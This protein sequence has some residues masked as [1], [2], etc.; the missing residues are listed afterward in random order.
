MSE[1]SP[2]AAGALAHVI[3]LCAAP[4]FKKSESEVIAAGLLGSSVQMAA[5]R[6]DRGM[7]QGVTHGRQV[8][9]AAHRAYVPCEW[10]RKCGETGTSLMPA[11]RAACL[12]V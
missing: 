4:R 6:R 9:A 5:S 8:C 11:N 10:R 7:T 1:I 2:S 12:E 3:V